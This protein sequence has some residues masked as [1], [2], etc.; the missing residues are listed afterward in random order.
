MRGVWL[1]VVLALGLSA[2]AN[3]PQQEP[4]PDSQP[5]TDSQQAA[6]ANTQLG[7]RYLQQGEPRQALRKLRKAL[8]QDPD[9]ADAHTVTGIVYERLDRPEQ[10]EKHY[11][12]AVELDGN[13]GTALNNYGRFL[14]DR[15][16]VD[17]GLTMFDR[18]ADN[19]LYDR[20]AVALTNAGN[21][22]LN[23]GRKDVGE[24][25][26]LRALE[27]NKTFPPALLRMARLRYEQGHYLNARAFYQRYLD[28]APQTA[29]SAWLGLR[30]EHELGNQDA[31]ASYR[32][33]LNNR[34]PESPETRQML[35]WESDGK[36]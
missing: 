27:A 32:L 9:N 13:N 35:E 8:R 1:A 4:A 19:P 14:C 23:A 18:A 34:F 24:D 7:V 16:D 6:S 33:L 22:A 28:A 2:C 25:Y 15:G 31:V 17:R 21:C 12:R 11:R 5:K 20:V 26:L 36:L 10:A 30:I 29:Q 3:V